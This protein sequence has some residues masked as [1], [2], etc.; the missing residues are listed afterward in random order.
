VAQ[1]LT[2]AI[3]PNLDLGAQYVISLAAVDPA[4]GAGVSG[5]IVSNVAIMATTV[6]PDIVADQPAP[7][8]LPLFVPV[9]D[10]QDETSA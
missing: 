5:V 4:S 3:P 2:A 9:P 7:P 8:E 6:L 1:K 10:T